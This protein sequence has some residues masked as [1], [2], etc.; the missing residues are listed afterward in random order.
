MMRKGTDG[1][2]LR[3]MAHK[4]I[5]ILA[6]MERETFSVPWSDKAFEELFLYPYNIDIVAEKDGRIA[7]CACLTMLGTEGEIDKVMVAK[8]FRRMGIGTM[9]VQ[10]LLR[11]AG[12]AGAAE[13][14]LEVRKSNAAAICLYEKS[15]FVSEGIRPGFYDKPREDAVIMWKRGANNYQSGAGDVIV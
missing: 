4:D 6:E 15:G 3:S 14:T 5:E 7:G 12:R 8:D 2:V 1:I 10:E 13:F 9:L 11:R